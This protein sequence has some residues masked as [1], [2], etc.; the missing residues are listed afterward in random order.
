[1]DASGRTVRTLVATSQ[2]GLNRVWWDLRFEATKEI[3]LRTAP[4]YAPEVT[5]NTQGWRPAPEARRIFSAGAARDVHGEADG[6]R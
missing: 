4:M 3:R 2:P 1:V 5:L 6:W